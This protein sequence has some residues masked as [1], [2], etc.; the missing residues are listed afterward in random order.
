MDEPVTRATDEN[1]T[2]E[3]WEL[4]LGVCDRVDADPENGARNAILAIQKRLSHR[5][6]NVQLFA[7]SVGPYQAEM[8]YR[9]TRKANTFSWPRPCRKIAGQRRIEKLLQ[10]RSL[11]H[12]CDL[13][14]IKPYMQRSKLEL[15]N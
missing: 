6:A 12:S 10:D 1:L 15:Q 14:M 13:S 9:T 3:N 7:L 4:I 11:R 2:S 5:N 8:F